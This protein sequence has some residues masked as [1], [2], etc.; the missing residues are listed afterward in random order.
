MKKTAARFEDTGSVRLVR[1]PVF[2][3]FRNELSAAFTTRYGGVSEGIFATMNLGFNRGDGEEN[4]LRNY[5]ILAAAVGTEPSRLVLTDQQHT[6]NLRVVSE[7]D[8]GKGIVKARDYRAVDGLVT[9][10]PGL[11][12]VT[13]HADCAPVYL[14]DPQRRAVGLAHAGW[15]G[16]VL[17]IGAKMVDLMR[18][19][20]GCD[21]ADLY[22][23]VGPAICGRCFEIGPEVKQEFGRMSIDV[24]EYIGYNARTGKYFP[25]IALIN[26]LGLIQKRRT[27]RKYYGGGLLYYGGYGYLFLPPGP[28]RQTGRPGRRPANEIGVNSNQTSLISY[29]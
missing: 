23:A 3:P 17:E 27:G 24:E 26:A 6:A 10:I 5:A 21:P 2:D 14:Y 12:L 29:L 25:D 28:S 4:V 15:K 13:I 18:E 11:A 19:A 22:A 1:F 7:A 16:T 9:D 20:F 8:A